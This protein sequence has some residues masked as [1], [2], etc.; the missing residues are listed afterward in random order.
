MNEKGGISVEKRKLKKNQIKILELKGDKL[1]KLTQE[2]TENLNS[3]IPIK[4]LEFVIIP[5]QRKL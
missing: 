1:S 5:S 4:V 3:S 2:E